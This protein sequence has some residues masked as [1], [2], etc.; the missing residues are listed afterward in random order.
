MLT[1]LIAFNNFYLSCTIYCAIYYLTG[2][3]KEWFVQ[4]ALDP[5]YYSNI[6]EE[7]DNEWKK[8]HDGKNV[9]DTIKEYLVKYLGEPLNQLL[10][11]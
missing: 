6:T 9:S 2:V 4:P 10:R 1:S 8:T 7:I 11:Y 3:L 5:D